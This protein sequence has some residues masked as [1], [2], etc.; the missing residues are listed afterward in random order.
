MSYFN[1][2]DYSKEYKTL[3]LKVHH[4]RDWIWGKDISNEQIEE[5]LNNF[6]GAYSKDRDHERF[7]SLYLLSQY[8][9]FDQKEIRA[10]LQSMYRD[11]FY[12]PLLQ[13]IRNNG[14]TSIMNIQKE[15]D[16][17][18]SQTRF[19]GIGN[20]SESSSLMLYFFRQ[21]IGFSKEMFIDTCNI[22]NHDEEGNYRGLKKGENS[23][24]INHYIFI[25]DLSGS[26]KQA[27]DFF[28]NDLKYHLIKKDNPDAKIYYLTLFNTLEAKEIFKNE[29]PD[30]VFR[31]VFELDD[32]YKVFNDKSRY[33]PP[34]KD[35]TKLLHTIERDFAQEV[36]RHY[37]SKKTCGYKDS[38]LLLSLFYNTPDNT[39]E[40]M[41]SENNGWQPIFKRYTK[42]Y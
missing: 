12:K 14:H 19:S 11:L 3:E 13:Q 39:I 9:F 15:Y 35:D 28:I 2:E 1:T 6:T 18:L 31:T 16:Q 25:D 8:M 5:W 41:R 27:R 38:Q 17:I 4:L 21:E 10:M 24:N 36:C 22:Y 34:I 37:F 29:L 40:T 23:K 30:I 20:L 33:F 32:T 42:I 26:G 7:S